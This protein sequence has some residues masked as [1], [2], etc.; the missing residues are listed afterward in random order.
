MSFQQFV[1]RRRTTVHDLLESEVVNMAGLTFF[2][3]ASGQQPTAF[4]LIYVSLSARWSKRANGRPFNRVLNDETAY[5]VLSHLS[6]R[7]LQTVSGSSSAAYAKWA[8]QRKVEQVV[9]NIGKD[10][11]IMW[12]GPRETEHVVIYCHGGGFVGPLSD[13]QVEF[14]YH[15]QQNLLK[16]GVKLGVAILAYSTYPASFPTQANQLLSVINLVLQLLGHL[17]HPSSLIAASVLVDRRVPVPH[18]PGTAW[19][20]DDSYDLVPSKSLGLWMDTYLSTTPES[21]HV[22]AQTDN[23]PQ[24]W[25]N[26]LDRIANRIL[27]TAGRNEVLYESIGRLSQA[28]GEHADVQLDVQDGGVHVDVMFDI[29]A[30][31]KAPHPVEHKVAQRFIETLEGTK[32]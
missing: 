30:R 25:I 27:I 20:S 18:R 13:F 4:F 24:D 9:E 1:R 14:W 28:M 7:Q 22:Y 29:G 15:V 11:R 32:P 3:A 19:D 6:V 26:G 23:A 8:K 5:F 21:H 31:S 12:V 16:S 17:L 2:E 10:T